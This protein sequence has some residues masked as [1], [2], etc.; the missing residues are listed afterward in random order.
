MAEPLQSSTRVKDGLKRIVGLRRSIALVWSSQP[1]WTIANVPLLLSQGVLELVALY[2]MKLMIDAVNKGFGNPDKVL[3]FDQVALV[4]GV[5]AA[6]AL[7]SVVF[8]ALSEFINQAQGF[9][10]TDHIYNLLHAKS[11]VLDLEHYENS[12]HYDIF[13]NAQQ[14]SSMRANRVVFGLTMVFQNSIL[15]AGITGLLFAV[16]WR[17]ASVLFFAFIPSVLVRLKSAREEY[18]LAH[19]RTPSERQANYFSA[20]LTDDIHAKELRLFNLGDVF[21]RRF[22]E[23]RK[24]LRKEKLELATRRLLPNV[25]LQ[26]LTTVLV[27]GSLAFIAYGAVQGT[28]TV[29]DLVMYYLAFQRGQM[30]LALLLGHLA[31]LYEDSLFL[32]QLYE[33][34]DLEK[35]VIE[36]AR[37]VPVPRSLGTGIVFENVSFDYPSGERKVLRDINL[38]IRPGEKIAIVGDNGSGKTTLIKLL[39]R[40][41]DPSAG[42]IMLDD[43]DLREFATTDLR[44]AISIVFQDY[45]HYS[46]SA[47]ENIWIGDIELATDDDRITAAARNSG[48]HAIIESLGRGYETLLGKRFDGE[49]LSIGEWQ[50]IALA[51]AYLR[52]AQIV[53]LDEPTSAMDAQAEYQVFKNFYELIKGR[54]AI[55]IS[56]RLSTVKMADRIYVMEDGRIVECGTHE[57]LVCRRGKYANLFELQASSYR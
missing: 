55:F 54:T 9:A 44:R 1:K 35:K 36:P 20:I 43:I 34:L 17:V 12:R 19:R 31:Y 18:E 49:E 4:I 11:T 56:H 32:T 16:D 25:G 21:M 40:L 15:L 53:V 39:C 45:V 26:V 2:L 27:F 22:R 41:Y 8:R 13:H 38:A 5:A 57:E 51:R 42:S 33:F 28:T 52:N 14:Q 3:A 48:A 23:L 30:Y 47:R 46:V 37:P 7:T 10:V 29:G 6:V 50:K 24:R